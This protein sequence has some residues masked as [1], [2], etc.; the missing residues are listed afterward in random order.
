MQSSIRGGANEIPNLQKR[1]PHIIWGRKGGDWNQVKTQKRMI[2]A[3]AAA[4]AVAARMRN[5]N[6][7][8]LILPVITMPLPSPK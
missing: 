3:I 4:E 5:P 8:T 1:W 2:A 7:P 6:H